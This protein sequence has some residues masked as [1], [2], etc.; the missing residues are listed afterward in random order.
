[1]LKLRWIFLLG[2]LVSLIVYCGKEESKESRA[3]F[4]LRDPQ[5][6]NN[7]ILEIGDSQYFNFDFERYV[8]GA[9]GDDYN[10]LSLP[11]LS[12][13]LDNFVDE[14]IL[15][16]AARAQ[17][18]TLSWEE[19]KE[20][21]AKLS[22]EFWFTNKKT[23][24]DEDDVEILFDRLLIEKYTYEVVKDIEVSDEEIKEYYDLHKREFLRPERVRVSQILLGTED[25]AIEVYERVKYASEEGFRKI[26]QEESIG[27]EAAKGGEMGVFELGQLP[28][29]MEKVVFS[30][31][32][33]ELSP[34]VES[35]YGYHI[36]RLDARYE[37]EL[38]SEEKASSSLRV[39]LLDQKIKQSIDQHIE[40]LKDNLEWTFYPQ[41]LAFP[42]QRNSL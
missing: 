32:V 37:A 27:I 29:E 3:G 31:K 9:V 10:S 18:I 38:I 16:Q 5:K 17:N 7:V 35:T 14:K 39:K 22:N 12:R 21:L 23:S 8:Q 30:L 42:Y 33:G 2:V 15:L 40:N 24:L 11:S 34:V 28:Y 36:F 25:K 19:K 13:L 4:D 41:N 20:Y 26:A 1:M 6:E